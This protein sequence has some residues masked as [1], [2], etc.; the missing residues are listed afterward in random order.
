MIRQYFHENAGSLPP[1][2]AKRGGNLAPGLAKQLRRN[3]HLP[4]G[5]EKKVAT[6]PVELEKRLPTLKPDLV[7]GVI[8]GRAVIFNSKTSVILD[9]FAVF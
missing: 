8:D 1:G 4:P 2:L 3:G 9:I 6:F 5:L 7:R